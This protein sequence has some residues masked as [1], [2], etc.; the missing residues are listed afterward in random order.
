MGE[1]SLNQTARFVPRHWKPPYFRVRPDSYLDIGRPPYLSRAHRD[2]RSVACGGTA[3][4]S[5]MRSGGLVEWRLGAPPRSGPRHWDA[6]HAARFKGHLPRDQPA[7]WTKC[8]VEAEGGLLV[9]REGYR[10]AG[11]C[12]GEH[13][14]CRIPKPSTLNLHPAPSALNPK[15]STYTL[16]PQP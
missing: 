3:D 9:R 7:C 1:C 2:A 16:H 12:H 5:A 10:G 4:R 14:T 13:L 11:A 6:M 8:R 15:P